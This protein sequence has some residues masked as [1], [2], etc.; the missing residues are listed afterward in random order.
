MLDEGRVSAYFGDRSILVS[1]I[2]DSKAPD[3]LMLAKNYSRS[4]PTRSRSPM[5]TRTFVSLSTGH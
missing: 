5:A 3:K 2:K 1:L 4:S